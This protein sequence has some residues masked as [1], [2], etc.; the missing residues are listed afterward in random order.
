M[1]DDQS[2]PL[3]MATYSIGC[4]ARTDA[5]PEELAAARKAIEESFGRLLG[6]MMVHGDDYEP[7]ITSTLQALPEEPEP[8]PM[9]Q[10]LAALRE[11]C[12]SQE[13]MELQI[14]VEDELDR[15]RLG[16]RFTYRPFTPPLIYP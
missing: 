14:R 5:A 15:L 4:L 12:R 9:E 16:W 7:T 3:K 6:W 1:S 11:M 8:V 13:R 2:K 10:V